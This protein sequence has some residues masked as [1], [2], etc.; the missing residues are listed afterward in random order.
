MVNDVDERITDAL[1]EAFNLIFDMYEEAITKI[2]V[3]EWMSGDIDYL[4]PA[5]LILHAI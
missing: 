2:P 1:V 3:S 4:I 5:R